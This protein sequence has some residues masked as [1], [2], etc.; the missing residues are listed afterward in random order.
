[1]YENCLGFAFTI[2]KQGAIL[3]FNDSSERVPAAG[4]V[5]KAHPIAVELATNVLR[6]ADDAL[7]KKDLAI[8][9]F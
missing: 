3:P 6:V 7:S 5:P 1:M 2:I 4:W 9:P 8:G